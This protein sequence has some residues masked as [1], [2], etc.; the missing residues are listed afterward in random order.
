M[1][2]SV[3][4]EEAEEENRDM[5]AL[6]SVWRSLSFTLREKETNG[7]VQ[8]GRMKGNM[9]GDSD[10]KSSSWSQYEKQ[11][12]GEGKSDVDV[13]KPFGGYCNSPVGWRQR[14]QQ[15]D[16]RPSLEVKVTGPGVRLDV[17]QEEE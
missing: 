5:Q 13:G 16:S 9:A 10:S 7:H 11:F 17:G 12:R 15:L 2:I 4:G 1:R 6:Q 8:V 14:E 3:K